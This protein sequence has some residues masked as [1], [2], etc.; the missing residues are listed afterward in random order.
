MANPTQRIIK[1]AL[2]SATRSFDKV[3]SYL[4][5]DE[6]HVASLTGYRVLVPF[7]RGDSKRHAWVVDDVVESVPDHELKCIL[8]ILSDEP[9]L[10]P[11]QIQL[12]HEMKRRYFCTLGAALNVMAPQSLLAVNTKT[13]RAVRL[14]DPDVAEEALADG[15]LTSIQQVRVLE[16]LLQVGEASVLDVPACQFPKM[17]KTLQKNNAFL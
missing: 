4:L 1:V 13:V 3:Y 10:R 17:L 12:A 2:C 6:R 7:G 15:M 11:D 16:Y 8:A 14:D 5:P 9:M